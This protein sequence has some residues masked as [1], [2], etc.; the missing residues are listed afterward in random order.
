MNIQTLT[1]KIQKDSILNN[2]ASFFDNEIYVVGGTV[3]DFLMGKI[4][5]D[6][7]LIVVDE[8]AKSFSQKV[9]EF[10]DGVFIPLDEEN[11]IYRIVLKDKKNFLDITNP[12][13]GNLEEDIMRRDITIN[14]I[15]VNIKTG[16]IPSFCEFGIQDIQN[17]IIR[18]IKEEN[19]TDDPLRILRVYRFYANLGFEISPELLN[20]TQKHASL[21]NKPAKERIEY[22]LMK[23]FDGEFAAQALLKMDESEILEIIFPFV[24]ELKQVPPNLHHHLDLFN[25]SIETVN[26]VQKF[27]EISPKE[28][29]E[30]LK[31]VDFGGFSRLAH[32][33]LAALMHDIGKFS[34]W[35]IEPDTG[36]HRFIKHEDVG[37]RLAIPILKKMCFSNKQID[38]ISYIIKKHMYPTAVVSAP[39][40]ND[41]VMMR[42]VRKSADN[43]ID[44]IIIAKA[45]RVSAQGPEI[46]KELVEENITLLDKLLQF[47][48]N[49]KET[50]TPLPKLLDGR[51]VMSILNI[52]PSPVLGK[53]LNELHEAQISGDILTKDDAVRFI[54]SIPLD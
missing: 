51:E 48:L 24:K 21:I 54:K 20:I 4:S 2:L 5:Y 42:Y 10:F 13:G 3:R 41:K 23:L 39:E 19:F 8:D 34:T 44:T 6:R 47:Y 17:K 12:I 37:A 35:T 16:E 53:I 28:V 22:E 40:Q 14:A 1:N 46:T 18:E 36:R 45:D 32:L 50:L 31:K 29:Q 7:D 25:H 30:H 11:K 38:Y 33:K 27:Y 43:A 52:N 49:T 9:A 15:A 26:Q